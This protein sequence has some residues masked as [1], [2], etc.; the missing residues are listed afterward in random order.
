MLR[1]V[2]ILGTGLSVSGLG[3]LP[4]SGFFY[5]LFSPSPSPVWFRLTPL[6]LSVCS[7][8]R[9][10][11]GAGFDRCWV[12]RLP[13][14]PLLRVAG[15]CWTWSVLLSSWSWRMGYCQVI[16]V[17]AAVCAR[18]T[19]L[20][21]WDHCGV[22]DQSFTASLGCYYE[23]LPLLL[24]EFLIPIVSTDGVWGLVLWIYRIVDGISAKLGIKFQLLDC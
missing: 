19:T 22:K 17:A 3:F 18:D 7:Y 15:L 2:S 1:A 24:P 10:N 16:R 13:L 8:E 11:L 14:F 4:F 20:T 21:G 12:R 9:T 23:L 5:L 6:F